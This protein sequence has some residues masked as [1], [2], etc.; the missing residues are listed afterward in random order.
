MAIARACSTNEVDAA[1]VQRV[2]HRRLGLLALRPRARRLGLQACI[3]LLFALSVTP[4]SRAQSTPTTSPGML[5]PSP[6]GNPPV[7]PRIREADL[8]GTARATPASAL[9]M[10]EG[11]PAGE[12]GSDGNRLR[13]SSLG[14]S[15][16]PVSQR[17][18]DSLFGAPSAG[19]VYPAGGGRLFGAPSAGVIGPTG[20]VRCRVGDKT[21]ECQTRQA[22]NVAP[23]PPTRSTV[24]TNLPAIPRQDAK[25]I[26]PTLA[27][28]RRAN[29]SLFGAPSAGVM[30]PPGGVRLFGAPSAGVMYPAGRLFGAPGAGMMNP[31][32]GVT[33]RAF[34]AAPAP[35]RSTVPTNLP[36]IP[37]EDA[38]P[39]PP[40]LA[41]KPPEPPATE[42]DPYAPIGIKAGNFLFKPALEVSTGFDSNPARVPNGRASPFVVVAPELLVRSQFERHQLDADLR[43][44]YTD[45]TEFQAF[46]H[47]NVDAKVKGR[48]DVTNTTAL[49]GEAR[50]VLDADDPGTP[51]I[52]NRFA[53]LP[54]VSTAGGTAGVTQDVGRVQVSVKGAVDRVTFQDALLTNGTT[55]SN[56]DRNFTQASGQARLTYAL[57]DEY[58][59]F[60]TASVDRRTHDLP[61][62]FAGFRR[63]STAAAVEAGM[64][65]ALGDKLTGDAAAGYLTRSYSDPKLA[66][67]GGFIADAMLVWQMTKEAS[68]QLEVK[69]QV[70]ETTEDMTSGVFRRD[71]KAEFDY[72]F[73]PWLTGAFKTGVGQDVFVGTPRVDD[74]YFLGLGLL[75]NVSRQ[76]QLKGDVRQEWTVSNK[77]GQN[78]SATVLTLG[79]RL[80]Y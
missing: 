15:P 76:V 20:G 10:A 52:A 78:L 77:V 63:D 62:D 4:D 79:G 45:T 27:T 73:Q 75:Y 40:T 2:C 71:V 59:P 60:V 17:P 26:P 43:G 55:V 57:T 3:V 69:S 14:A 80:Q 36:A 44:S 54:L 37:R 56:Q 61:V 64:T 51:R 34:N 18:N 39:I 68:V 16:T 11:D 13:A 53:K 58:K 28:A 65:F 74:R 46:S 70:T 19:V 7:A 23:P 48:Y 24:P 6:E 32:D 30:Y 33:R 72:Q 12:L 25:P 1:E 9:A 21:P 66:G 50:Y 47:P 29:D 22:F 38:K 41:T 67:A 5:R 31:A 42:K 49:N 35:T 8:G